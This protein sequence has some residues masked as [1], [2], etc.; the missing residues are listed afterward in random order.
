MI[1]N[2][3]LAGVGGQGILSIATVIGEAAL[4]E[5][6]YQTFK[7]NVM[8]HCTEVETKTVR[9]YPVFRDKKLATLV[10]Q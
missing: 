6:L 1:K 7:E 8:G 4:S 10:K 3:I 5:G 9:L 2:I